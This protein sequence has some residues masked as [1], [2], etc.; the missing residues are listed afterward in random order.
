MHDQSDTEFH[1]S[2]AA[3]LS[4]EQGRGA[5]EA[6]ADYYR[7]CSGIGLEIQVG[8]STVVRR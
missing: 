6:I 8:E 1:V 4:A 7:A 2:F 5:L 3:D